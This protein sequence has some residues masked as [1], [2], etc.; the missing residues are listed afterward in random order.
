MEEEE[1]GMT[2][3]QNYSVLN[4]RNLIKNDTKELIH[5]RNRL[6]DFKTKFMVTKGEIL[7]E[8]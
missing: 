8:G 3:S 4:M 6:K 2:S 5:N 7:G 1:N